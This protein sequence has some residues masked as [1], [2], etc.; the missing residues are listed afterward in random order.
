MSEDVQNQDKAI[1]KIH[2]EENLD[3]VENDY[4]VEE[5]LSDSDLSEEEEERAFYSTVT[6]HVVIIPK[7]GFTICNI[8]SVS[9]QQFFKHILTLIMVNYIMCLL[10]KRKIVNL[11]LIV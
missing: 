9:Y 6:N 3:D 11:D 2:R 7:S 5:T 4:D 8:K 1:E 10:K